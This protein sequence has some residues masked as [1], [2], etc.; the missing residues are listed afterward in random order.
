MV[1]TILLL[2]TRMRQEDYQFEV[3]LSYTVSSELTGQLSETQ[4]Q[5][6]NKKV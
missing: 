3:N 1:L 2:V 6:E 5:E 4:S